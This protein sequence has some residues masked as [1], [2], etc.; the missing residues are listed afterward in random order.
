M[1]ETDDKDYQLGCLAF[2]MGKSD[3]ECPYDIGTG[4][5]RS[6]WMR[7]YYNSRLDCFMAK[8]DAKYN[9]GDKNV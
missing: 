4:D 8:F 5:P 1:N 2:N 6:R 3:K 7:G 9:S